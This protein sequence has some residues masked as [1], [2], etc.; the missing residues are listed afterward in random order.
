M[1]INGPVQRESLHTRVVYLYIKLKVTNL[2]MISVC[3]LCCLDSS[4]EECFK[5]LCDNNG[6]CL[7]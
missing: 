7:S 4:F 1:G 2:Y 5:E 3:F 6:F